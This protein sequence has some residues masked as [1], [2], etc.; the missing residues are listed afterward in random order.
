[1]NS[2]TAAGD[3]TPVVTSSLLRS[4]SRCTCRAQGLENCQHKRFFLNPIATQGGIVPVNAFL[5]A[6]IF[7]C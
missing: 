6:I 3:G 2:L 7:I 4:K 5:M 1:M